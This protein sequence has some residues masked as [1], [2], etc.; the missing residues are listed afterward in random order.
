MPWEYIER[1]LP[2]NP[3]ASLF[4]FTKRYCR[5]PIDHAVADIVPLVK[6]DKKSTKLAVKTGEAFLRLHEI[7]YSHPGEAI[8]YSVIDVDDE[9]IRFEI[10][11]RR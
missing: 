2:D 4:E 6:R 5:T 9:Y 7:H 8:A 1:D 10:F 11:R 3:A